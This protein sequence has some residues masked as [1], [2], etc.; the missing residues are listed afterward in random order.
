MS[1]PP[2]LHE[3]ESE[4]M[5]EMWR[6]PEATVRDVLEALNRGPKQRAYTTIMTIMCRLWDKGL[7][8]RERRGRTDVYRA[9]LS[10]EAYLQTRAEAEV[11]AVV[12]EFGD[13]ALS[14]FA[15]QVG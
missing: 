9:I 3:L 14:H 5:E 6:Q 10:R 2:A 7:L 12:E 8:T 11:D 15:R 1:T 13:L 4:V